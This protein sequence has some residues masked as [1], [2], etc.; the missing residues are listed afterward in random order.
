MITH[1]SYNIMNNK[2]L[3]GLLDYKTQTVYDEQNDITSILEG[4][5]VISI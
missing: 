3:K 2:Y 5:W 1:D 4:Q